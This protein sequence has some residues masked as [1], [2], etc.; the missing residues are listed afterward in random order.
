MVSVLCHYI[1]S[2]SLKTLC[3]IAGDSWWFVLLPPQLAN[4]S[5][6]MSWFK[7]SW[8]LGST[9]SLAHSS[10]PWWENLL[11]PMTVSLS[12]CMGHCKLW[13]ELPGL[14]PAHQTQ[15]SGQEKDRK[16]SEKWMEQEAM[17]R[18]GNTTNATHS[19][20]QRWE[21]V[22]QGA[23]RSSLL[24]DVQHPAR[25]GHEKHPRLDPALSPAC[26]A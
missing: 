16:A 15:A 18:G 20:G 21:T 1:S 7:P 14:I 2:F 25:Q 9:W 6:R 22:A 3:S 23:W 11:S 10:L 17:D 13:V 5:A 8:H 12:P 26:T 19:G 4:T 24:G